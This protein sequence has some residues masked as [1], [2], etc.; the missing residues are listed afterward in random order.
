MEV[1]MDKVMSF[2]ICFLYFVSLWNNPHKAIMFIYLIL[3]EKQLHSNFKCHVLY[4][5][6]IN[7]YFLILSFLKVTT[8][9]ERLT[10]KQK[11]ANRYKLRDGLS[12]EYKGL[13]DWHK[14]P[15]RINS[16]Q[17]GSEMEN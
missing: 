11:E 5:L 15:D 12:V 7:Q 9:L 10:E 13:K 16:K 17:K 6:Y 14:N 4:P 1:S 8:E 3:W 2:I